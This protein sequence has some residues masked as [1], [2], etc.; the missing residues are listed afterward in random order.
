L[1]CTFVAGI[2]SL[3]RALDGEEEE[4]MAAVDSQWVYEEEDE[5]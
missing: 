3:A 1:L 4:E 2:C 5:R